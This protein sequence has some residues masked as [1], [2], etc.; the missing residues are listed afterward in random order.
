[1]HEAPTDEI[2]RAAE[3][4]SMTKTPEPSKAAATVSQESDGAVAAVMKTTG[5]TFDIKK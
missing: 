1:M 5:C 3:N 4:S 2:E